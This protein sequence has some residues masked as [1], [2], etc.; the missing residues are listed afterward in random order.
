[1]RGSM[2]HAIVLRYRVRPATR[3]APRNYTDYCNEAVDRLIDQQSAELD[4]PRRLGLVWDIQR[5]LEADVARPMLGWRNEY[6]TAWP[7]VKNLPPHNTLYN[8]ARMQEVW[9]DR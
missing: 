8:Y 4:R 7:Y 5:R 2:P 9:L 1:M 3:L 6:F